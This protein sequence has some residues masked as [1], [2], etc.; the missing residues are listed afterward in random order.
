MTINRHK[1]LLRPTRLPFGVASASAIFSQKLSKCCKV[2]PCNL[3]GL[4]HP[5]V[6]KRR[7][8]SHTKLERGL[9]ALKEAG[10]RLK[11]EK[12]LGYKV[13]QHGLHA[14]EKKGRGN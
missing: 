11:R 1:G 9:I 12:Y 14:I 8:G 10:L 13:D 3:S 2:F 5:R 7:L 6:W 4:R